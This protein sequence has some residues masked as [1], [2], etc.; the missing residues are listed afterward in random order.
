MNDGVG[1]MIFVFILC[2]IPGIALLLFG[3]RNR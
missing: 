1:I 2:G 3:G